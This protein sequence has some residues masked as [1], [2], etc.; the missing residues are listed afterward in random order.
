MAWLET[1]LERLSDTTAWSYLAAGSAAAEPAALSALALTVHGRHNAA[2]APLDWLLGQQA[3]DG[4]VG[5]LAS[6]PSPAWPTAWSVLAWQAASGSE[7]DTHAE[8]YRAAARRGVDWL[9]EARGNP[10]AKTLDLGHNCALIGWPWVL[11]TH[12]WVEPTAM[13]VLAL[14]AFGQQAHART[15][16]AVQLLIDRLLPAG[17]CNYGNTVCAGTDASAS[18]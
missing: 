18:Y 12:S 15:R 11:G 3:A 7:I 13:A 16:E 14:K 10:L 1:V 4:G 5:A 17:G 2:R 8:K 9:L 6:D